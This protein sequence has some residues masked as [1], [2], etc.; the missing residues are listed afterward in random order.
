M[1]RHLFTVH[2]LIGLISPC[3]IAG[4][5]TIGPCI[6]EIDTALMLHAIAPIAQIRRDIGEHNGKQ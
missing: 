6:S 1:G 5:S 3:M 2:Y 4:T